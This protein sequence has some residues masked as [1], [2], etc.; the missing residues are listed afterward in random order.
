M[1]REKKS[2]QQ[3]NDNIRETFCYHQYS[4]VF[5]SMHTNS[6]YR[7]LNTEQESSLLNRDEWSFDIKITIWNCNFQ[8]TRAGISI[9]IYISVNSV[10]RSQASS[11][12]MLGLVKPASYCSV[13]WVQWAL[14]RRHWGSF[15]L[16]FFLEIRL[17][18]VAHL[19]GNLAC[20]STTADFF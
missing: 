14:C 15:I 20:N 13:L 18:F 12:L 19:D 3:G 6:L 8:I 16:C 7:Y 17:T 5:F 10:W 9:S 11:S 2:K 1:R 4:S